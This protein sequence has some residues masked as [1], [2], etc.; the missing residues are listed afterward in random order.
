MTVWSLICWQRQRPATYYRTNVYATRTTSFEILCGPLHTLSDILTIGAI[1]S[2]LV[3]TLHIKTQM[4]I[5]PHPLRWRLS[6]PSFSKDLN[7]RRSVKWERDNIG[8]CHFKLVKYENFLLYYLQF[9]I[10]PLPKRNAFRVYSDCLGR[11][12]FH[13]MLS[14]LSD[15]QT[16]F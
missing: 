5:L 14:L 15:K 11:W 4:R 13:F 3:I 16:C 1:Y 9:V 7:I 6:N 8:T 2:G 10:H 12:T